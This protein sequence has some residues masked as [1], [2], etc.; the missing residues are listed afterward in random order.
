MQW[1]QAPRPWSPALWPLCH[2]DCVIT[3][4]EARNQST[5][6]DREALGGLLIARQTDATAHPPSAT[7]RRARKRTILPKRTRAKRLV[8][9][10]CSR[11]VIAL[12]TAPHTEQNVTCDAN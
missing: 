6:S 1:G 12:D 3:N 10:E 11:R 8:V 4:Q 2:R 5:I 9:I 7:L